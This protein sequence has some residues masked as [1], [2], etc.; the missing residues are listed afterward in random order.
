M[1][2]I[3]TNIFRKT[4]SKS[5][6]DTQGFFMKEG[7]IAKIMYTLPKFYDWTTQF[8]SLW[9]WEKWQSRV[10][11][12]ITG[13]K[14]LEIGVGPGRLYLNLLKKGFDVE[15]T[16]IR[17]GLADVARER[18]RKA[19]FTPRIHLSSVYRLPFPENTFDDVVMTFVL[20]EIKEL[21]R[22]I[23]EIKRV[24]KFGGK[25][26]AVSICYPQDNNIIAKFIL[27]II[28]K[29]EDFN[30]DR[31]FHTYFEKQGFSVKREDFGPFNILNKIVA[32]KK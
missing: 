1:Y 7:L 26:V 17:K 19:G 16:E 4:Q 13:T 23:A 30:L 20:G 5:P 24:L 2:H 25:A 8:A 12:D 9:N 15:A 18:A 32:V 21:D 28:N 31:Q 29:S 6:W 11:E 27:D 10:F 14:V 22:A 3:S